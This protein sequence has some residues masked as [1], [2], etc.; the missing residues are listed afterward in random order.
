MIKGF[1]QFTGKINEAS[2]GQIND[3]DL[4]S[5]QPL[6][7]SG[8]S[9]KLNAQAATAY[10]EM[11]KAA[12][13]D[14]VTWGITDSY[15]DYEAQ[16]DV[17]ARKGLYKNGGLAA[18]PGTSNHGWGSAL[19]LKL[20]DKAQDWLKNNAGKFGFS[21]IARE[22]WHWEHKASVDFA[23]TGKE[24]TGSSAKVGSVL[25]DSDL[26]K[27]LLTKLKEKNFSQKDLDQY[28][29]KSA[30]TSGKGANFK[31]GD[32]FPAENMK[33]IEKAMD[34]H[35]ITNEYARKA[36]LGVISKES[37]GLK[38]E[39]S[40]SGTSPS[41][42]RE[43]F[44]SKFGDKSDSEIDDIKK[45]DAMFW[46]VVYGGKY[47]NTEPGDGSKYRGRGFNGITFK[48]NYE[49]LQRIYDR[50]GA[51]VGNIDIVKNPELLE[52]PE[53]AAEFAVLYFM[54]TFKRHGKDVNSYTDL[55]S[56]VTDYVQ[57]NAGWGT[58]L[59]GAVTSKGL[60]KAMDFAKSLDT[61]QIA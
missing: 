33:A 26:I 10:E 51:K 1:D 27:R 23:K 38:S 14:D 54:D 3:T 42:I 32:K 35:G 17:A 28:V 16:V 21:T 19:D 12:E 30:S 52:K 4:V 59:T 29:S 58:S 53:V 37:P 18:V 9:H 45:D 49:N 11:K 56:A 55:E 50:S 47:G 41:R 36:I 31:S 57:A 22:P 6:G 7:Q 2:N 15:R 5:I 24:G 34:D 48:S 13:A 8:G 60:Q 40:Y 39:I 25:I 43:V 46:D 61:D 20:D 44:P